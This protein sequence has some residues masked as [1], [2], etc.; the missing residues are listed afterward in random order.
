MIIESMTIVR[1]LMPTAVLIALV[2]FLESIAVAKSLAGRRRE[3]V[4]SNQELVALG[5]ANVCGS[6]LSAYP[7]SGSLSR[8][9]LVAQTSGARCTPLHGLVASCL[10]LVVLPAG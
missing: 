7:T 9:A 10:V 2:S 8:S 5:V 1:A 6:F 4:D 3:K